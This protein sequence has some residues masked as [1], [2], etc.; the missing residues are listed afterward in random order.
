MLTSALSTSDIWTDEEVSFQNVAILSPALREWISVHLS[1]K[2]ALA[3]FLSHGIKLITMF[4]IVL[5]RR[6]FYE[7]QSYNLL[8]SKQGFLITTF[9]PAK[10]DTLVTNLSGFN[11]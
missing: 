9:L 8:S 7:A 6:F 4:I 2:V 10:H 3:V 11:M 1:T 5:F